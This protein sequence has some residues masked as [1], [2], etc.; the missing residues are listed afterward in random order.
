MFN[1]ESSAK[2]ASHRR[3]S[4]SSRITCLLIIL[5][6]VYGPQHVSAQA[7]IRGS[8]I[9]NPLT[10]VSVL[11][12][13]CTPYSVYFLTTSQ[14]AYICSAVNTL[15]PITTQASGNSGLP[16]PTGTAGFLFT[17]G[18]TTS[19]GNIPTGGS[20][21]L[22]C[23][24]VPG[25]CDI[26][27]SVVPRLPAANIFTGLNTFSHILFPSG[28]IAAGPNQLPSP[29]TV[30][31]Q[32]FWATDGAS[33]CDTTTG[34][35]ATRILLQS[36][37]TSWVA[38]NCATGGSTKES[39][40]VASPYATG[41]GVF[42]PYGLTG[43]NAGGFQTGPVYY[44]V[45]VPAGGITVKEI[46]IPNQ[47]ANAPSQNLAVAWYNSACTIVPGSMSN[48]IS[49]SSSSYHYAF[50]Y[51]TPITLDQGTYFIAM[52]ISGSSL[53]SAYY[54]TTDAYS[55]YALGASS[56]GP[57]IF[58][59]SNPGTWSGATPTFPSTCGAKTAITS[60]GFGMPLFIIRS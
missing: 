8:Q 34:G 44:T 27:T 59:G 12:S 43:A 40:Q 33:T 46:D 41:L 42:A 53:A 15:T 58:T 60:G 10:P 29:G 35:G 11:P 39:S 16:S 23:S 45:V 50:P 19:W 22:D 49:A 13:T 5:A 4:F 18:S 21:A 6:I 1:E 30:V 48:V 7:M 14:S 51:T 56:A 47:N 25:Q 52:T 3:V 54:T 55:T 26:V 57:A 17:N 28:T 36:D 32:W 24:T 2:P 9:R 37:G 38:P 20:G 31:N